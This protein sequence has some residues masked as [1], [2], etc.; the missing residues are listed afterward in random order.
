M[1]QYCSLSKG[2]TGAAIDQHGEDGV[3]LGCREKDQVW[4]CT[5][6]ICDMGKSADFHHRAS[7]KG[8][9]AC[10]SQVQEFLHVGHVTVSHG[11]TLT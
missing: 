4:S 5:F 9:G 10:E 3:G 6:V 2:R 1:M 8:T 11:M 7:V